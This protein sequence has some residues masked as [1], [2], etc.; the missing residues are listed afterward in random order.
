MSSR[1]RSMRG[2]RLPLK[3]S[4]RPI[5]EDLETRLALSTLNVSISPDS[6]VTQPSDTMPADD[7][8]L[9]IAIPAYSE[10]ATSPYATSST[11]QEIRSYYG[12][13]DASLGNL[14][15]GVDN[16]GAGQTI[17]IVD[18]YHD[19]G[20]VDTGTAG[21]ATSDLGE[22]DKY[23]GLPDPPSLTILS[24]TGT[25]TLPTTENSDWVGEESLDV[26]WA[27]SIAPAASIDVIEC[28]TSDWTDLHAGFL[29]AASLPGVSVVSMSISGYEYT[30]ENQ[31]ESIFTTPAGHQGV[32]FLAATGD[33]GSNGQGG[34]DPFSGEPAYLS[35]VVAVGGTSL[36]TNPTTGT[37][38]ETAWNYGGGGISKY[39]PEPAYQEGVQSSGFRE[40]PDVS[41]EADPN[42]G[43]VAIYDSYED[44]GSPWNQYGG[45]SLATPCWAGIVAITDQLRV[46]EGG[47]TLDG[48]SQT[49]PALYSLPYYDFN[50]IVAG[51]NEGH[52]A[53]P[54]YDMATGL[55]SPRANLLIPDLA[56]Y[57]LATKVAV[58]TEPPANVYAGSS[59]GLSINVEDALGNA[60]SDFS[61]TATLT[62][63]GNPSFTSV[64]A[65]V[66]DGVAIFDGLTL[67]Q[68]GS[69]KFQISVS[70]SASLTTSSVMTSSVVVSSAPAG[71]T[72]YFPAPS[73]ASLS[74]AISR[75][76]SDASANDT[77][78]LEAGIYALS[79]STPGPLLIE[80][81]SST[82]TSK[83]ITIVGQGAGSTII[84]PNDPKGWDSRIFEILSKSGS[85]V[86]VYFQDL[87][88]QGGTATNSGILSGTAALG[89][90]LLIDGGMVALTSVD[91]VN[92]I[93][94][95]APGTAGSNGTNKAQRGGNGGPGK[96]AEGGGIYLAGGTLSLN[97]TTFSQ[98]FAWGGRGG[99]GGKGGPSGGAGGSG[100][101]G[102]DGIG[103]GAYVAGGSVTGSDNQFLSDAAVGGSGG[104]GGEGG[105]GG[106]IFNL[107]IG[108]NGGRGAGALGGGLF[109]GQGSVNLGTTAFDDDQ[110]RGGNGGT[111]G[112]GGFSKSPSSRRLRVRA[113]SSPARAASG[114][115]E[116][117]LPAAVFS[118]IPARSP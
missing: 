85:L 33:A 86:T 106:S 69:D 116:Q 27:H 72:T 62:E 48:P 34:D 88:I 41:F 60:D 17:A 83:T 114:D 73:Y 104:Y 87:T 75:A 113:Y 89:G 96:E 6:T 115:S 66:T 53:Q 39:V 81:T 102:G 30:T 18:A 16:E 8:G 64:N 103:G 80:D 25:T 4:I 36:Y 22:F 118:S 99:A 49:L 95:G 23:F 24:E 43:G 93:A 42:F 110:A 90:G 1:Q 37:T 117:P 98:D 70:G 47:T 111:G 67:N 5:L 77:I 52:G 31:I 3:R 29:E 100:A 82:V 45:T 97:D 94:W 10:Q 84:V 20:F 9:P 40:T 35:N 46:L 78:M 26:E 19:P 38:I 109:L 44:G 74:T 105:V 54:G 57:D 92:N 101:S 107:G 108:G 61:G 56:A 11:P 59:F 51:D 50:D 32:T 2:S 28:T 68:V 55:G 112:L 58:A 7:V 14:V 71:S 15:G 12:L 79:S 21:F 91:L 63:V 13:D 76:D 65:T